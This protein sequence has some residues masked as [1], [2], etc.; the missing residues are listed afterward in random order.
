MQGVTKKVVCTSWS[1]PCPSVAFRLMVREGIGRRWPRGR[2]NVPETKCS[3][4]KPQN[5]AKTLIDKDGANPCN[6]EL[7]SRPGARKDICST[8]SFLV[9]QNLPRDHVAMGNTPSSHKISAQDR[10]VWILVVV[11]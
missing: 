2:D 7:R 11:S 4:L 9:N 1:R 6:L 5:L 8:N 10:C 3:L